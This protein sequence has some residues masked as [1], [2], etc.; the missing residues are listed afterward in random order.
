M[1]GRRVV[2][3]TAPAIDTDP[4]V[5]NLVTVPN[6]E[7]LEVGEDWETSTGVFSF[8]ETDLRSAIESQ[9]D[10]AVRTPILKLGHVDQ[11]FDGQP[12][13][14]RLENLRT[15]NNDQT[16]VADLTG[17]PQWLASIMW[18]AY[19][20]R[21][22]EGEYGVITRTGNRWPFVLTALALLGD[23]YPA[24]NTLE[25]L[26][27]LWGDT[28]PVLL[29][30]GEPEQVAASTGNKIFAKK[31]MDVKWH[32]LGGA[33]GGSSGAVFTPTSITV[34]GGG[35]GGVGGAGGST[36]EIDSRVVARSAVQA[37]ATTFGDLP[38]ADRE[39]S[40]SKSSADTAVRAWASS[41]GS[42]DAD[43]MDWT[44]YRKA[45][46]WYDSDNAELF[47]SYKLMFADVIDGTLTAIPRGVFA[48]AAVIQGSRG[49][50][51][52]PSGDETSVKNT[53]AKYYTKMAKEFDDDTITPPWEVSSSVKFGRNKAQGVQAST[54]LDQVRTAFYDSLDAHQMWWWVRQVLVNPL[55]L[56][57]DDD[58]GGLWLIDVTVGTDETITFGEP[59]AIKVEYVAA[60][61]AG[62]AVARPGQLVASSFASANDAGARPRATIPADPEGDE[63]EDT[64][65][66]EHNEMK[67]TPEALAALGLPPEASDADISAAIIARGQQA[68]S[69][70]GGTTEPEPQP[71]PEPAPQPEAQP[72]EL[73]VPEGM[74]LLDSATAQEMREL[75]AA[76]RA[77]REAQQLR[78]RDQLL[79]SAVMAGK[80]PRSRLEHYQVMFSADPE[81]TKQLISKMAPGVIPVTERGSAGETDPQVQTAA[82]PEGW[83]PSV[84]A[85]SRRAGVGTRVKVG[86]D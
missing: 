12:S 54:S 68:P 50:V 72:T 46:F 75:V 15:N 86:N 41:D 28:P 29:T 23:A 82:Y 77:E 44:K 62:A 31:V 27:N 70:S 25:D 61:K 57:V 5:P 45:F 6:V 79:S 53:I 76:G 51:D 66:E 36:I 69:D 80:F 39:R 60:A 47:G 20:R 40:W 4:F 59:S 85:S 64:P 38:L 1:T 34:G 71:E 81:G 17:T 74:E 83:K 24:I 49:G 7:I 56:V 37:G 14:G 16:L 26:Q 13:F 65:E 63:P 2:R 84:A 73:Q 30:N 43:K 48:A 35:A 22:I 21:S 55:Q 67:L 42:G 11:R 19:P 52:I 8:D 32:N 10:P 58:E 18:A 3:A 78:D 9:A 33:N